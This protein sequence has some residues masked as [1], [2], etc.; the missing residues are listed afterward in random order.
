MRNKWMA[1]AVFGIFMGVL[2]VQA[3][4]Q[5][6]SG[7]AAKSAFAAAPEKPGK[8]A[9]K[10]AKSAAEQEKE[11]ALQNP[12]PNDL[13]P[14]ELDDEYLK[15]L[16]PNILKGYKLLVGKKKPDGSY[17]GKCAAC[18]FPNRPLNS[19]FL[20][21][22]GKDD[23][24]REAN[25]KDLA[26]KHKDSEVWQVEAAIW[27]RYVKRMSAKPGCNVGKDAKAIWEFLVADSLQRKTGA[28]AKKWEDHRRK[29][30]AEFKEKYPARHKELFGGE[31]KPKSTEQP[32]PPKKAQ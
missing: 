13:G 1:V 15:T 11:K 30:L 5:P 8:K 10:P 17:D 4:D 16:S 31:E 9:D 24:E 32:K 21:A 28:N 18:H 25:A 7:C 3:P 6:G 12:Y 14:N 23:K 2:A 27:K 29:L 19:Q 22:P 26:A 20:E